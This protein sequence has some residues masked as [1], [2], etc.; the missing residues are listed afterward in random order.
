[1]CVNRFISVGWFVFSQG[2]VDLDCHLNDA[3]LEDPLADSFE[4]GSRAAVLGGTTTISK[5]CWAYCF[6]HENFF[7]LRFD[8]SNPFS[9]E[10]LLKRCV[11]RDQLWFVFLGLTINVIVMDFGS[12]ITSLWYW[13]CDP[14]GSLQFSW[15]L[16]RILPVANTKA[17]IHCNSWINPFFLA[18]YFQTSCVAE[19][20][21]GLFTLQVRDNHSARLPQ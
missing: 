10:K 11:W 4:S 13:V 16:T 12:K 8:V 14:V 15:Q 19:K 7:E 1:M 9:T 5:F 18:V 17:R 6:F 20:V 3:S 21:N 2:G